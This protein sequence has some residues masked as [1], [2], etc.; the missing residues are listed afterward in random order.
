M[1]K[2][3]IQ[4]VIFVMMGIS[5]MLLLISCN[6]ANSNMK[7]S[8]SSI[9]DNMGSTINN[10][11]IE[12]EN[13]NIASKNED[14]K[15]I[16]YSFGRY[17]MYIP[18]TYVKNSSTLDGVVF[19]V[20]KIPV[21]FNMI[22]LND[23]FTIE[24][25]KMLKDNLYQSFTKRFSR[26]TSEKVEEVSFANTKGL[27]CKY[28]GFVQDNEFI[29]ETY[30]LEDDIGK[31]LYT[32]TIFCENNGVNDIYIDEFEDILNTLKKTS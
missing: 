24:K 2:K 10:S 31:S 15:K 9:N 29:H 13:K 1:R 14:I 6:G 30:I 26:L 4:N 8:T 11:G 12:M 23:D 32:F 5:I 28:V 19:L 21:I 22:N 3:N 17:D 16:K 27:M 20:D 25:V 18:Q 7:N